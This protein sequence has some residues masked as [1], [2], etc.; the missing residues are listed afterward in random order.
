M[1]T[2]RRSASGNQSSQA[3]S[4]NGDGSDRASQTP[5]KG[6]SKRS[7]NNKDSDEN[8]P[9]T[10]K[11]K[12]QDAAGSEKVLKEQRTHL[13]SQGDAL[14]WLHSDAAWTMAH[15]SIPEAGHAEK[16]VAEEGGETARTPPA[17]YTNKRPEAAGE[18]HLSYP[19]SDLSP[20]QNLM[21]AVL[22]SKPISHRL[23][24][25]TIDTLLNKPYLFRTVKDLLD[26]G[27]EGRRAGLWE[28]RT[29][30]KEKTAEQLGNLAQGISN[31]CNHNDQDTLQPVLDKAMSSASNADDS[32]QVAEQVKSILTGQIN[33]LGPGGVDIFLRRVQC[34][35]SAVFPFA[36]QRALDAAS[37]FHLVSKADLDK[38]AQHA[39]NK[40]AQHVADHVGFPLDQAKHDSEEAECG[41]WWFV[42]TL[43]VLIG[44]DIEKNI[45]QAVDKAGV[46]EK[47]K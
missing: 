30:H 17:P 36:D 2:T 7:K 38:G 35:W 47:K 4:Q 12:T 19:N 37:K 1:V 27:L 5:N 10:K 14:S 18:G 6:V 41:R 31:L 34:Q 46:N 28:A 15:P 39:T 16:D 33:G 42:R 24:L 32:F 23:G 40:L 11:Q 8:E 3:K 13:E 22:L 25:R 45:D 20:F 21:C 9:S 29:Q 26:A 43:D 44:L